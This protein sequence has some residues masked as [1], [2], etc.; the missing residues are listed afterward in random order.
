MIE[1]TDIKTSNAILALI[2][3]I[4][5]IAFATI[6]QGYVIGIILLCLVIIFF[7][8]IGIMYYV[9]NKDDKRI[10]RINKDYYY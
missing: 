5:T 9:K 3:L 2:M 10:S 6:L 8:I 7:T 4:T 1:I